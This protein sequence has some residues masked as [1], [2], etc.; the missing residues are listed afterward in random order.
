MA[1]HW[2][3]VQRLFRLPC[4]EVE[5]RQCC[6]CGQGSVVPITSRPF[7][8]KGSLISNEERERESLISKDE[9]VLFLRGEYIFCKSPVSKGEGLVSDGGP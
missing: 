5:A 6:T 2:K 1:C 3:L 9:R 8:R 4:S 7:P